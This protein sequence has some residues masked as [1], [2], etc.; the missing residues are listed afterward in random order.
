MSARSSG[1]ERAVLFE[2]RIGHANLAD[3][4]QKRGDLNLVGVL[5]RNVHLAR[6]AKRPLRQPRAVNASVEI[7][8]IEQLVERAD[9]RVAEREMLLLQFLDS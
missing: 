5:F 4:M 2:N 7:L 8:Q 3:V 6:D 1:S 9:Q